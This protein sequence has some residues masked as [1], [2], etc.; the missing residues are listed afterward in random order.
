MEGLGMENVGIVYGHLAYFTAIWYILCTF[1][2][3]FPICM[4]NQEKSGNPGRRPDIYWNP[5]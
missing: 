3:F 2:I 5:K 1:G 4:L